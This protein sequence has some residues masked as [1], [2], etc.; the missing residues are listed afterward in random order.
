MMLEFFGGKSLEYKVLLN[1]Y[2]FPFLSLYKPNYL[3]YSFLPLGLLQYPQSQ[4]DDEQFS[5]VMRKGLGNNDLTNAQLV[6][7]QATGGRH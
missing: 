1:E 3:I 2:I 7:P 4:Q 5:N 6:D